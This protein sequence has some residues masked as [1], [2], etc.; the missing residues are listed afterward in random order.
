M[1]RMRLTR[2]LLPISVILCAFIESIHAQEAQPKSPVA[3]IAPPSLPSSSLTPASPA[4][5]LIH[6]AKVFGVHPGHALLFTVAATGA[7]PIRFTADNLPAGLTLAA[8]TGRITGMAPKAGDYQ[9]TLHAKNALGDTQRSLLLKVG[10]TL[11]LTPP[12]GWNSWNCFANKVTAEKIRAA[13]DAMVNSGLI[14]H[15]WTYI[16]IDDY[17]QNTVDAPHTGRWDSTL[18]GPVRNPDGSINSNSRFPDMKAL[19]DDIHAHGLKAGLYSSP[20]LS[21]CGHCEGSYQHDEQDAQAYA[22]WGFDYLKYDWCSYKKIYQLSEG[23]AGFE[24]PYKIMA[25]AIAA[26]PRDIVFSFCQYGMGEVWTWGARDG[27][28][29]WRTTG[30]IRDNWKSML[31]NGEKQNGLESFAG[32]GHWNDPDMLVVGQVAWRG[33]PHRSGLTADEQYFHLS[34]WSLEA[35]PLLIGCDLTQ[36]DAFTLGLLTNDEV[37]DVDQDSLGIA[38]HVVTSSAADS[39]LSTQIWARP[40]ENGSVAVGLFNLGTDAAR[41]TLNWSDLKL[42]GSLRVRDLWREKDLGTFDQKFVGQVPP[43]GVIFVRLIKD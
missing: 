32:P 31:G 40:L 3:E 24:K 20:G 34:L 28:N 41:V 39:S 33:K 12:M 15:G 11:A 1:R 7:R 13:A 36:L 9:V 4:T 5:P 30:D 27:G 17:W 8:S 26:V 16:N 25:D 18:D 23:Q 22:H 14:N 42:S 21:T 35:A 2:L 6:G 29:A 37:I 10:D 43:H 38:A 19:A